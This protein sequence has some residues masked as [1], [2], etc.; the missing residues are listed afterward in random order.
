MIPANPSY[1]VIE[2]VENSVRSVRLFG[3][4]D[5]P[6]AEQLARKIAS[7]CDYQ[8][9]EGKYDWF[10]HNDPGCSVCIFDVEQQQV[11]ETN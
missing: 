6:A 1:A 11:L 10:D 4:D 7:E 2:N 5:L 3:R 9:I 8:Q